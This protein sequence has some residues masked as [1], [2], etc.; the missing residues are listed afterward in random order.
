M[1]IYLRFKNPGPKDWPEDFKHENGSYVNQCIF[2]ESPFVGH[3]RRVCCKQCAEKE[4]TKG[5]DR[6]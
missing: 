1:N 6:E 5:A 3:K 2:C 4:P